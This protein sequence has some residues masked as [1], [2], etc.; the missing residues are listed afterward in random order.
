M[1]GVAPHTTITSTAT[2]TGPA[3]RAARSGIRG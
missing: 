3:A 1:I 2:V